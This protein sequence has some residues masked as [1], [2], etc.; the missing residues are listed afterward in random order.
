MKRGAVL[1]AH[2]SEPIREVIRRLLEGAG[3]RVAAVADGRAALEGL[4]AATR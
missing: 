3:Y 4:A 1:V 2:D